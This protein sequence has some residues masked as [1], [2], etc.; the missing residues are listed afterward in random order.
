MPPSYRLNWGPIPL[1][2]TNVQRG[3]QCCILEL[4]PAFK[5]TAST[6]EIDADAAWTSGADVRRVPV[7][8]DKGPV[9][10][11]EVSCS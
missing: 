10:T 4:L 8:L 5:S 2:H 11:G 3:N 9:L 1:L 6:K 7:T